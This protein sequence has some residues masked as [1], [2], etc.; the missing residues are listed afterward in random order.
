MLPVSAQCSC[1]L[2]STCALLQED[3]EVYHRL[4]NYVPK[5]AAEADQPVVKV[6]TEAFK[7]GLLLPRLFNYFRQLDSALLGNNFVVA[8][9]FTGAD[10]A[11]ASPLTP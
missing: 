9:K 4:V 8:G 6:A 7:A 11:F 1:P 3:S 5:F 10:G 2:L